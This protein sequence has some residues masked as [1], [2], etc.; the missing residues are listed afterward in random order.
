MN[1]PLLNEYSHSFA[2]RAA[3]A[4]DQFLND[5]FRARRKRSLDGKSHFE[6]LA[7][8]ITSGPADEGVGTSIPRGRRSA[9]ARGTRRSK[10]TCE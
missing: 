4:L 8:F 5:K 7:I 3:S 6:S 9:V 1:Q 10:R 2:D